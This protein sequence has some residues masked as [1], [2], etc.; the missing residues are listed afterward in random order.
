MITKRGCLTCKYAEYA[1]T[2]KGRP[3]RNE[4]IL[5]RAPVPS[6]KAIIDALQPSVPS[7]ML[8]HF[9]RNNIWAFRMWMDKD[10]GSMCPTWVEKE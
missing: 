4:T 3:K 9:Y 5:C 1:K 10:S 6:M 7:S 8:P 2:P